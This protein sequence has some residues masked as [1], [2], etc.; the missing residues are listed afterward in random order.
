MIEECHVNVEAID[1][2]GSNALHFAVDI[3]CDTHG[4]F[5]IPP[6]SLIVVECFTQLYSFNV[7]AQNENGWTALHYACFY[8]RLDIIQYLVQHC[9]AVVEIKDYTN[10]RTPLYYAIEKGSLKIVQYLVQE[11]NGNVET[12][13]NDGNTAL[14]IASEF[15]HLDI[16]LLLVRQCY[17]NG[18]ALT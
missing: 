16:I 7:N 6:S 5:N 12:K 3:L 11:C 13:D 9:H 8:G 15:G 17:V 10:G 14:H 1:C 18:Y 2:E 4:G